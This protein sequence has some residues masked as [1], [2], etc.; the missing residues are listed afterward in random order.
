MS[1]P[2]DASTLGRAMR[3]YRKQMERKIKEFKAGEKPRD[4]ASVLLADEKCGYGKLSMAAIYEDGRLIIGAESETTAGA[5]TG[6]LFYL[7]TYPRV[8]TK[9]RT[10]LDAIFP[11]GD[12]D[13]VYSFTHPIP[14][15]DDIITELLRIQSPAA[16]GLPRLTPK[17][18]FV[19]DG[20][21]IPGDVMVHVPIWMIRRQEM[22]YEKPE[23]FIPERWSEQP[24]LVKDKRAYMPFGLGE[25]ID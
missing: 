1:L 19:I 9:L 22:Y 12:E 16:D 8:L 11:N 5:L 20:I 24:D 23:E 10:I 3:W 13:Y 17:E 25:L 2:Q 7:H 14:Y 15:I 21:F 4:L 18:G 6:A